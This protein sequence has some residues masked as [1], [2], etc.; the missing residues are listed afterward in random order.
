[1]QDELGAEPSNSKER[2]IHGGAKIALFSK[3]KLHKI[4]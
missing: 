1:M 3:P 2:T 4:N